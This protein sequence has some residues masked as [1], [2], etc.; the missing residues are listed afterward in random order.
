[1]HDITELPAWERLFKKIVWEQ[2][3]NLEGKKILDFG[4]ALLKML[5]DGIRDQC[6][7]ALGLVEIVGFEGF[8]GIVKGFVHAHAV[9]KGCLL[10]ILLLFGWQKLIGAVSKGG[11]EFL[12]IGFFFQVC[13]NLIDFFDIGFGIAGHLCLNLFHQFIYGHD[14]IPL[15]HVLPVIRYKNGRILA[16]VRRKG[17]TAGGNCYFSSTVLIASTSR[18]ACATGDGQ[19]LMSSLAF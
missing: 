18:S 14:I 16:A 17:R 5:M 9:H 12:N 8:H 13:G 10:H 7:N 4:I 2:L 15:I 3:G 1:M 11:N 6:E 19:P